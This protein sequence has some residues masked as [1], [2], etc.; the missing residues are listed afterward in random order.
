MHIARFDF[1][2]FK[3]L[4]RCGRILFKIRVIELPGVSGEGNARQRRRLFDV[5]HRVDVSDE[6]HRNERVTHVHEIEEVVVELMLI[7]AIRARNTG[8]LLTHVI[9][10]RHL[11]SFLAHVDRIE[12]V[13]VVGKVHGIARRF[14]GR[15]GLLELRDGTDDSV[16]F[17]L[18]QVVWIGDIELLL[19]IR[20]IGH[21]VEMACGKE[22]DNRAVRSGADLDMGTFQRLVALLYSRHQQLCV[23]IE[24]SESGKRVCLT[25]IMAHSQNHFYDLLYEFAMRVT[26]AQ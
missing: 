24:S 22:R 20:A 18:V 10:D 6:R 25:P 4:L 23:S 19:V 26:R 12:R 14:R 21:H 1:H 13:A 2:V 8:D 7:F 16:A 17:G 5:F 9:V 11:Q 15:H 3:Q